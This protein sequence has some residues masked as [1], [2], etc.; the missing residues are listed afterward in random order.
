MLSAI[1]A[2]YQQ[3]QRFLQLC[4]NIDREMALKIKIVSLQSL[5]TIAVKYKLIQLLLSSSENICHCFVS[6]GDF[7]F[8]NI[9]KNC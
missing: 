2:A 6:F 4:G 9:A 8:R 5:L 3:H 7:D 1:S